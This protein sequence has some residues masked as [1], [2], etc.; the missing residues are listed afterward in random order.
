MPRGRPLAPLTLSPSARDQLVTLTRSRS[1]P[2]ALVTRGRIVL[3]A[4]EGQGNTLIAQRLGLAKPTVGLWRQR[5]RARGLQGLYDEFRPGGPRSIRDETI[6]TLVRKTLKTKPKDGTHWTCRSIAAE[7]RLSKSTVQRVWHAFGL[8]PHRQKHFKLSPDPFFVEKVRDIVGLYLD[9]PQHALVLCVDE[10]SQIQAL[11]RTQPLLPLGLGYVEGITHD[12][13]RHGTTTLF[14]ALDIASGQV[15]TQCK[16][17]HRHQEFLQFLR[18]LDANVP[19]ALDVHLVV[20][21]YGT[22]KHPSVRR[23]LAARPRYHVHYTPTYASWLNQ[24]EIWFNIITQRAIRRGTFRSVPDLI[25]N[26]ERFVH[27]YNKHPRPFAWTA[28]ADSILG[29]IERLCKAVA[30]TRH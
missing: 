14:A 26:I 23:W 5:Y 28:T 7:T 1:M 29:K 27:H 16:R 10:K 30:G 6:A 21:N 4:A 24:V 22:H 11:D 8:Q 2:H 20:D 3:L 15:L 25:A 12:Y 19:P 17:R 18:H 9:P 13:I